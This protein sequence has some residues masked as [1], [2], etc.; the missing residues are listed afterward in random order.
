MKL[1]F[2][3]LF[4]G[5]SR[6][7]ATVQDSE[8]HRRRIN[9]NWVEKIQTD[10]PPVHWAEAVA[11]EVEYQRGQDNDREKGRVLPGY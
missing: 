8:G 7:E 1:L 10:L 6:L 2:T 5:E 4:L 11:G 9:F 3:V